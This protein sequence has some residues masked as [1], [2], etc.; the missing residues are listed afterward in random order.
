MEVP[1]F[2]YV[3]DLAH[4]WLFITLFNNVPLVLIFFYIIYK[5]V[6]AHKLKTNI[7]ER[8]FRIIRFCFSGVCSTGATRR[9]TPQRNTIWLIQ[10]T[11]MFK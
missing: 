6:T 7:W 9:T 1:S 8:I 10:L 2:K 5:T 4:T 3:S 11:F